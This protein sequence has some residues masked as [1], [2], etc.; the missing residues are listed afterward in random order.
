MIIIGNK[1]DQSSV[2]TVKS[3]I[4]GKFYS[5][6]RMNY[7]LG[8]NEIREQQAEMEREIN[9]L[10]NNNFPLIPKIKGVIK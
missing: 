6:K 9:F 10:M 3:K 5:A 8:S 7:N 2:F 4:D 1:S